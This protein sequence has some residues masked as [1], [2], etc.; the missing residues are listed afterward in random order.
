[1]SSKSTKQHFD[2]DNGTYCGTQD[3][4]WVKSVKEYV[5]SLEFVEVILSVHNGQV[6]QI[7]KTEKIRFN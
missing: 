7:Q 6:V 3:G 1:M 2:H 4:R 5:K